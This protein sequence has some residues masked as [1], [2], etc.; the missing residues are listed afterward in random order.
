MGYVRS[1]VEG[2]VSQLAELYQ[3]IFPGSDRLSPQILRSYIE[4]V[5]FNNPWRELA[6]PSLVYQD[7]GGKIGGFL[8]VIPRWM[9]L[10]GQPLRVAVS[11]SFMVEPGSRFALAGVELLKTFLSGPQDLSMTDGANDASRRL[12]ERLSGTAVPLYSMRWTRILRPCRYAMYILGERRARLRPFAFLLEP[13]CC[14]ADNIGARMPPN[15]FPQWVRRV[16]EADLDA[17]TLLECL[18]KLS[19]GEAL[20]PA[21]DQP[22]LQWLL[23]MAAKKKQYGALRKRVVRNAQRETL[24]WWL[25]YLNRGGVSQVLQLGAT[26]QSIHEVLNHLFYDAWRYGSTAISGRLEPRFLGELSENYASF[27]SGTWTL[28]HS[29][30]PGLLQAIYRGDAVLTRLEGEWWTCFLELIPG[31]NP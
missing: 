24:G 26:K 27:K 23:E 30:D 10:N 16:F 3:E 19:G 18:S 8:G 29:K 5:F 25:Y 12:W 31:T 22:S 4:E 1:F 7:N 17:E 28:V 21:Y 15:R 9:L 11:N 6:L 13:F 2:D 14:V 20:Q